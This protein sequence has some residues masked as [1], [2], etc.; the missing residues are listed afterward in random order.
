MGAVTH[1]SNIQKEMLKLYSTDIKEEELKD[2]KKMIGEYFAKKASKE[3][4]E[5]WEDK[6]YSDEEMDKWLKN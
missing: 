6:G 4:D 3:A 2:I 5:I 1:L